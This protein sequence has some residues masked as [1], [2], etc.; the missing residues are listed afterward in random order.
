[1]SATGISLM[2]EGRT[3]Q[4]SEQ[5]STTPRARRRRRAAAAAAAPERGGGGGGGARRIRSGSRGGG[6]AR[7]SAVSEI[8]IINRQR[9]GLWRRRPR[10]HGG[11]R[12]LLPRSRWGLI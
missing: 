5:G 8:E 7:A 9:P 1:M 11:G 10:G 6:G 3:M 2:H 4:L 12:L